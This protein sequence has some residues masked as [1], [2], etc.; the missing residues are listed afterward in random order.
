MSRENMLSRILDIIARDPHATRNDIYSEIENNSLERGLKSEKNVM[1][2]LCNLEM[3]IA[4][5]Q[6]KQWGG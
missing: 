4:I 1:E 2:A 3:G 5:N 6:T